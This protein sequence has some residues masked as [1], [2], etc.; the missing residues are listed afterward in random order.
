[1][2]LIN[3][4][5]IDLLIAS[6]ETL[7]NETC[8][9]LERY[10]NELAIEKTRSERYK[11]EKEYYAEQQAKLALIAREAISKAERVFKGQVTDYANQME[12]QLRKHLN[13]PVSAQ[14]REKLTMISDFELQP[15]RLEIDDLLA[16]NN[17][18]QTGLAALQKVLEKVNSPYK[19]NYHTVTDF[20]TDI[21]RI[22]EFGRNFKFIPNEYH[23]EGCEIYKREQFAYTYP[24]GSTIGQPV[25]S[26]LLLQKSSEFELAIARITALKDTWTADCSYA[27]VDQVTQ[28]DPG[29][30]QA[31]S[32]TTVSDSDSAG[33]KIAKELGEQKTRNA[34]IHAKVM[35]YYGK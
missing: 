5:L 7:R 16:L 4:T 26:V 30:P 35:G 17:G 13:E 15:E 8:R 19:L 20:Q 25:D 12:Q 6:A 14:F 2:N 23:H 10:R 27:Q 11:A 18:N 32:N 24:N 28:N 3:A 31:K 22:R 21:E 33:M 9:I 34:E 1:M 29:Q